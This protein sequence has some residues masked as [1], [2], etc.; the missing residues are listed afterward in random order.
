MT[1]DYVLIGHITADLTP[2]GRV[3]GGTVSYA[4]RTAAAFGWRVAIVTSCRPDEP[5]LESLR[6]Y[7]D[8]HVIPAEE[9][10]TFENIYTSHGRVQYIR[11]RAETLVAENIPEA[12]RGAS[13]VHLGP[14]A[15]EIRSGVAGIFHDS[16]LLATLQGWM[17]QWGA[18]QV[19]RFKAFDHENLLKRVDIVVFSEEDIASA[20]ETEEWVRARARHTFVTRAEKGG[21]YYH[22]GIHD[23][24]TSPAVTV[25][26]PTGAGDVF[27]ASLLASLP[28]LSFEIPKAIR[29]AARLAANSV[30]RPGLQGTPTADEV[31]QVLDSI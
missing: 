3:A 25:V 28:L 6:P 20:P 9:T 16:T 12:L 8:I 30:T 4:A 17:R 10:T 21:S 31:R 22:D 13:M 14:I 29:V 19:V 1:A 24:Y 15:D 2:T 26:E 18:D 11:A 5:L 23:S 27:A 7:A